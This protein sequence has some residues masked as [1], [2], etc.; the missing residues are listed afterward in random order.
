MKVVINSLKQRQANKRGA[1]KG[2]LKGSL[3]KSESKK[4]ILKKDGVL[5]WGKKIERGIA[6]NKRG[7]KEPDP[8]SRTKD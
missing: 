4:A 5:V 3:E 7:R 1:T 8:E 2:I 6:G